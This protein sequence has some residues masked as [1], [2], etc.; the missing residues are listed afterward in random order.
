MS[1]NSSA[2]DESWRKEIEKAQA[3]DRQARDRLVTENMGLV[4]MVIRRFVGRGVDQE[5][6]SQIGAIGLICAIDRFDPALPYS[7]STYAVPLIMGEIK[8]FFRSDGMIHISRQ[9]KE[10]ARKIAIIREQMKKNENKE[11]TME[12]LCRR[13]GLEYADLIMAIE[14]S[15]TVESISRPVAG[16]ES[17]SLTLEDQLE[18]QNHFETPILNKLALEQVMDDLEEDE[19]QL[20]TLR[21]MQNHTQSEVAKLMGTNQVAVSRLERKILNKLRRRLA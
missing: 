16:D 11:P 9:I 10:N 20:I 4:Y 21:Y 8:R 17:S 14:A 18:D 5:E 2:N 1:S 3:G 6:L 7:F 13:T 19:A 12:E 15:A